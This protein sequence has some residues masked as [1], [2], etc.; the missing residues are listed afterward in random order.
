MTRNQKELG[1]LVWIGLIAF[2]LIGG[3]FSPNSSGPT[4]SPEVAQS[5]AVI[6][7]HGNMNANGKTWDL[8]SPTWSATEKQEMADFGEEL[9]R[10]DPY[11]NKMDWRA[12]ASFIDQTLCHSEMSKEQ[13]KQQLRTS[14]KRGKELRD[15]PAERAKLMREFGLN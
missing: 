14:Y 15:N 12:T 13:V 5:Q 3:V 7:C 6:R 10:L 4:K 9:N 1:Q 8:N 11:M 2:I